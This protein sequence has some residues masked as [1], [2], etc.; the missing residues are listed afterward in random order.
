MESVFRSR[1]HEANSALSILPLSQT[2]QRLWEMANHSRI[3]MGGLIEQHY[4]LEPGEGIQSVHITRE[5]IAQLN[6]DTVHRL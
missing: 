4:H 3:I 1:A 5:S 2:K 6:G